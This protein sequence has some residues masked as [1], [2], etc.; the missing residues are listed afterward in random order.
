[1]QMSH[2]VQIDAVNRQIRRLSGLRFQWLTFPR[3]LENRFEADTSERR[4]RRLW[5][6]GLIAIVLYDLFLIADYFGARP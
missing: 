2:P 5:L 1:M 6:E 4:C 3:E